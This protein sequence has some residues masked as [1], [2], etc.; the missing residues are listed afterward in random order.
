MKAER[1]NNGTS[2]S[3]IARQRHGKHFSAAT[4]QHETREELLEAAFSV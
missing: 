3:A 2:N 4:N 1:R